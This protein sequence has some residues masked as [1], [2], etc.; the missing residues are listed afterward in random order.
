MQRYLIELTAHQHGLHLRAEESARNAGHTTTYDVVRNRTR[1]HVGGVV[2]SE[3][4]GRIGETTR[5]WGV[6]SLDD[7]QRALAA[8]A[9]SNDEV[10]TDH[11]LVQHFWVEGRI[12]RNTAMVLM[13]ERPRC[14][15]A[16][17]YEPLNERLPD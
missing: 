10:S 14:A 9:L 2:T 16:P 7:R 3:S 11:E 6:V 4:E 17:M 12:D 1:W 13:A 15:T 8:D 5:Y